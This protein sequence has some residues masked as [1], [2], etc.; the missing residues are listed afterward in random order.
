VEL[1]PGESRLG[2]VKKFSKELLSAGWGVFNQLYKTYLCRC[3]G[4]TASFLLQE[5]L[6]CAL[7]LLEIGLVNADTPVTVFA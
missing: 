2:S 3:L 5:K 6:G 7:N 1:T 4:I